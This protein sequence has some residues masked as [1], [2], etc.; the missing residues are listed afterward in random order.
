MPEIRNK[1]DI[2]IVKG[3]ELVSILAERN[4]YNLFGANLFRASLSGANLSGAKLFGASLFGVK[5]IPAIAIAKTTIVPEGDLRVWKKCRS[6]VIVHLAIPAAAKR[7][8]A[9]DRKCRAEFADVLDV[10]GADVGVSLHDGVT[11]YRKGE[12]V[13]CDSWDDD[14]WQECGGGIHFYLTRLEAEEHQ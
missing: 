4:K 3:E 9:S 11:A 12:R 14:R 8:N 5:N 2:V 7:S 6:G 10:I 1:N 13:T